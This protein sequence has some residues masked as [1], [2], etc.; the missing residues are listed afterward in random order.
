ML[1]LRRNTG[2]AVRWLWADRQY[3]DQ[4]I[5]HVLDD[6]FVPGPDYFLRSSAPI[7]EGWADAVGWYG[8]TSWWRYVS[9]YQDLPRPLPLRVVA[10]GACAFRSWT[11]RGLRDHRLADMLSTVDGGDDLW[12]SAVMRRNGARMVRPAGRVGL[13]STEHQNDLRSIKWSR[14]VDSGRMFLASEVFG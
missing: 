12:S 14:G 1:N 8:C 3:D 2:P 7:I 13:E 5:V 4:D 10:G 11:L 9:P 6:D